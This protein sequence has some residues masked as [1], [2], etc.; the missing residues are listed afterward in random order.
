MTSTWDRRER[1]ATFTNFRW[2]ER[3]TTTLACVSKCMPPLIGFKE[4]A[5]LPRYYSEAAYPDTLYRATRKGW[6]EKPTF[7]HR[8]ITGFILHLKIIIKKH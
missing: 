5:V 4:V 2:F 1:R 6:M 7:C 8:F 3:K